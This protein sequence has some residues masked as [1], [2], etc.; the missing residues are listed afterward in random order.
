MTMRTEV[1]LNGHRVGSART[2][3]TNHS[4]AVYRRLRGERDLAEARRRALPPPPAVRPVTV[5]HHH[6]G[7]VVLA[8]GGRPNRWQLRA[9]LDHPVLFDHPVDH[10]PG[11]LLMEAVRQAAH[12]VSPGT[13]CMVTGMSVSF[14]GWVEL[15]APAWISVTPSRGDTLWA[16]IEQEEGTRLTAEVTVESVPRRAEW[17]PMAAACRARCLSTRLWPQR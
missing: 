4:A 14:D 1:Q 7:D 15:D 3:F 17:H 9:D 12:A 6:G 13:D 8:D 11:M 2:R 5:G 10:A 16:F